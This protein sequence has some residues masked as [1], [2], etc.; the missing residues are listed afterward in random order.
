M[1]RTSSAGTVD[2]PEQTVVTVDRSRESKSGCSIMAISIVGTPSR[3][4][5]R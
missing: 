5:P 3:W 1:R 2:P 4:V